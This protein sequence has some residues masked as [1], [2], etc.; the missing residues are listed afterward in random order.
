M[1]LSLPFGFP[2]QSPVALLQ[3]VPV[4]TFHSPHAPSQPCPVLLKSCV[5][6]PQPFLLAELVMAVRVAVHGQGAEEL[7]LRTLSLQLQ[8]LTQTRWRTQERENWQWGAV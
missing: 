5:P 2:S 4:V 6:W 8:N 7:G 3:A 1:S